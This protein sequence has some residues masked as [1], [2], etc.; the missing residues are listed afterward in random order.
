MNILLVNS[1]DSGGG[2]EKIALAC[3][4]GYECMGE[5]AW[6]VVGN[7][8]SSD[9]RIYRI[10]NGGDATV[11]SH[12]GPLRRSVKAMRERLG[13]EDFEFPDTRYVLERAP[14]PID[15]MHCHNL[16]GSY[17]DLRYLS[18]LSRKLPIVITLHDAWLLSGHCGHSFACERWRIGCG[19]CP[20]LT[21]HPAIR[22]DATAYNWKRKAQIFEQSNIYVATPC[23]W[24]MDKVSQS[25]LARG[26]IGSRVI[27]NGI[28]LSVFKPGDRSRARRNLGLPEDSSIIL[29]VGNHFRRNMFKDYAGLCAALAKVAL[30]R[31]RKKAVA[32]ILGDIGEMQQ[33]GSFE[34]RFV[35]FQANNEAVADYFRAADLYVH[36][37]KAETFPLSVLEAAACGVPVIASAV[38]GIPEEIEH[39]RTGFL[40]APGDA[41]E[42][43]E[44]IVRVLGDKEMGRIVGE[45]AAL[46]AEERF[47]ADRM[48]RSYLAWF[49]EILG[50]DRTSGAAA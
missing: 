22:R 44:N 24:L 13:H 27:P 21:I 36:A 16:H 42:L 39:G 3:L 6:F 25:V 23:Q 49:Q 38:G 37:A 10:G 48:A 14:A 41:V 1:G 26:L 28:D 20:D 43:A 32:L 12:L 17:F 30:P 11:R 5:S 31:D 34:I 50:S 46:S 9:P 40:V 7:K 35:P 47:G 15:L 18:S 29:S 8:T 2:A 45:A 33:V 4:N 19:E